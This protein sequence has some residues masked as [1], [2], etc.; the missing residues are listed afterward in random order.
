MARRKRPQLEEISIS[1]AETSGIKSKMGLAQIPGTAV[2]PT[3]CI[4]TTL[5]PSAAA[6]RAISSR[7]S[8][9]HSGEWGTSSTL[10]G[11][12]TA[13]QGNWRRKRT[14]FW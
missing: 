11:A 12:G 2:E 6:S 5:G 9:S 13:D 1:D 8:L 14:S 7:A 4:A 10:M 3:W